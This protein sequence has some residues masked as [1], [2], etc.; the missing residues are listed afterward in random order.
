M[1]SKSKIY[2]DKVKDSQSNTP[3]NHPCSLFVAISNALAST[4]SWGGS[5]T[6]GYSYIPFGLKSGKKKILI[7]SVKTFSCTACVVVC[8]ELICLTVTLLSGWCNWPI[9]C[10]VCL[11]RSFRIIFLGSY[12]RRHFFLSVNRKEYQNP[13]CWKSCFFLIIDNI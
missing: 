2:T 6:K 13:N 1:F 5:S 3:L 8:S 7:R 9:N 11:E 4:C 12:Q 10:L